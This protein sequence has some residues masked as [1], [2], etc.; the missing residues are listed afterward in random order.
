MP[1]LM[2]VFLDPNLYQ[3]H[4][5]TALL[6]PSS[7]GLKPCL[8]ST[9]Y[10]EGS[11]HIAADSTTDGMPFFV[12]KQEIDLSGLFCSSLHLSFI[13]KKKKQVA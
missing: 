4:K 3:V 6:F 11:A 5:K 7:R 10:N 8:G 9:A 13:T 1:P 12:G 2:V